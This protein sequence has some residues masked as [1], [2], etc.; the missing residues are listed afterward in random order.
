MRDILYALEEKERILGIIN[1]EIESKTKIYIGHE[2]ASTNIQGCFLAVAQYKIHNGLSGRLAL[3]GPTSMDYPKVVS[4]L[5][6]F[7]NLIN[8]L[9]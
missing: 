1:Q 2:I 4:A 3:L 7:S 5:E 8:E 6:Y 9:I